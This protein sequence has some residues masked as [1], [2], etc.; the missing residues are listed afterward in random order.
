M[1]AQHFVLSL[2][3]LMSIVKRCTFEMVLNDTLLKVISVTVCS[4]TCANIC[5]RRAFRFSE[6]TLFP[7]NIY[8]YSH[9]ALLCPFCV[10][11]CKGRK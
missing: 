2:D 10:D 7:C 9:H 1:W 5:Y 8:L 4:N 6:P 3:K 11:C